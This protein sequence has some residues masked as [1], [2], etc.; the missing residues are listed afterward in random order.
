MRNNFL[1]SNPQNLKKTIQKF[2]VSGAKKLHVLTNFHPTLTKAYVNGKNIPSLISVLRDENYLTL[3]Y[4]ESA[5]ALYQKYHSIEINPKISVKIKTQK[6][7]EWW[8]AHF[9]LLINSGLTKKIIKEAMQSSSIQ[10]REGFDE[11]TDLL[12]AHNIPLV[13]MSSNGLG[14]DSIK[15]C[16][17]RKKKLYDNIHIISNSYKWNNEGKAIDINKPIIHSMN[18]NA[19]LIRDFPKI[20]Q[21]V[22]NRK[23]VILMG[24]SLSDIGMIQG[25]NY[26]QLIKIGFL[27]ENI[28]QNLSYY[29]KN[30]DVLILNDSTLESV[31]T[32]LKKII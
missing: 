10:F 14:I 15:M 26:D 13:I 4:A 22:Q 23:N 25:F 30:Y 21:A 8:R 29:R 6:M 11:F 5:H 12:K 24:D 32:L 2:S 3:K 20:F 31:N 27:N 16:L 28:K 19:T 17:E 18:K 9:K 1:I 7:E